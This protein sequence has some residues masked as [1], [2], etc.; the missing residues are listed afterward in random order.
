[1]D[2]KGYT[3]FLVWIILPNPLPYQI[4]LTQIDFLDEFFL[5]ISEEE[6]Y[7]NRKSD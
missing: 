6:M 5:F 4:S 3:V 2:I 7:L 1:M